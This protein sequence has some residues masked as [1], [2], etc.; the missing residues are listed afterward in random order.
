[1]FWER[2]ATGL[3]QL[4]CAL[5]GCQPEHPR[6]GSSG[7]LADMKDAGGALRGGEVWGGGAA[8]LG[9]YKLLAVVSM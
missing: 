1:M 3:K 8:K 6:K 7:W 5:S 9:F 2:H 4:S